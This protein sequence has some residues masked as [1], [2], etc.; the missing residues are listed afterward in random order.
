MRKWIVWAAGWLKKKLEEFLRSENERYFAQRL[1]E[2]EKRRKES[3][4]QEQEDCPHIAGCNAVSEQQDYAGR[5]SIVWHTLPT[6]E[7]VGGCLNC[8]KQFWSTDADY[9]EWMKKPSFCRASSGVDRNLGSP[10]C[11]TDPGSVSNS[12]VDIPYRVAWSTKYDE[13][14]G[15]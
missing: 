6:K 8:Q 14:W 11:A 10:L 3:K 7:T 2:L 13:K 15:W 5:T 12:K 1:R 9:E 4:A